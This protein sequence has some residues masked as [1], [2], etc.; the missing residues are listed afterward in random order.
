MRLCNDGRA[1][2]QEKKKVPGSF[3]GASGFIKNIKYSKPK[4]V[5]KI[6]QDLQ[7][8]TLHRSS[9][10]NFSRR[11]II[12]SHINWMWSMDIIIYEKYKQVNSGFRSN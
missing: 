7:T 1:L 5:L 9:R 3:G 12:C 2:R 4:E 6:L 10:K 8:Y 11:P